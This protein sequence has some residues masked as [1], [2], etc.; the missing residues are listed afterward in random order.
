[1]VTNSPFRETK[2]ERTTEKKQGT[3]NNGINNKKKHLY[4]YM[5][6]TCT[7]YRRKKKTDRKSC[8]K[9]KLYEYGRNVVA[10]IKILCYSCFL[11]EG[12]VKCVGKV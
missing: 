11:G 9:K 4:I 12:K 2:S 3:A 6:T 10:Q 5:Y 7:R 8:S 1:M